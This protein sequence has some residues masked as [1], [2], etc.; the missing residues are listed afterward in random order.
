[1]TRILHFRGELAEMLVYLVFLLLGLWQLVVAYGRLNG[2]SLSGYPDRR[3]LSVGLGLALVVASTA[4]YFSRPGHFA[5]P[6]VEGFETLILLAVALVVSTLAQF[7][8]SSLALFLRGSRQSTKG[9]AFENRETRPRPVSI[10]VGGLEV[11]ALYLEADRAAGSVPVLVLHDYGANKED[12]VALQ[13]FFKLRG[14]SSMSVDLDG[15]GGNPRGLDSPLMHELLVESTRKLKELSGSSRVGVVGHGLGGLLAVSLAASDPTVSPAVAID[16]PAT[17][18]SGHHRVDSLREYSGI[19]VLGAFL[20]PPARAGDAGR[21]SLSLLLRRL[22]LAELQA[23]ENVTL[24]ATEET[25]LN[26]PQALREFATTT[27][28]GSP[29]SCGGNHQTSPE[30]PRTLEALAEAFD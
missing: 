2:L 9:G 22:P 18:P 11:A 23:G 27:D 20:R 8:L 21:I 19:A 30:D 24:V 26:S 15:H 17:D 4:V 12:M 25:W 5:S 3:R 16:P 28:L 14:H 10:V 29:V 1:M 6:D 7:V 13:S